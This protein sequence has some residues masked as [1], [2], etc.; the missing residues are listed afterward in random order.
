LCIINY[1]LLK[2]GAFKQKTMTK[3]EYYQKITGWMMDGSYV[4]GVALLEELRPKHEAL[5]FFKKVDESTPGQMHYDILKNRLQIELSDLLSHVEAL[6][7]KEGV[8]GLIKTS[9]ATGNEQ[10]QNEKTGL[11]IIKSNSINEADLPE[12]LK[13]VF[14]RAKELTPLMASLHSEL[15]NENLHADKAAE[16]TSELIRLDDERTACWEKLDAWAEGRE[17]IL[18]ED[19]PEDLPVDPLKRGVELA[20]RINRLK[21]NIA[22]TKK[23]IENTDR[24]N[25]RARNALKLKAYEQE[26][27]D[28]QSQL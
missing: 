27:S 4:E 5:P 1:A 12:E 22:R 8:L 25:I 9:V 2:K 15:S 14:A 24:E 3:A 18:L 23:T 19:D 10:G 17:E 6:A 16:L 20:S 28:L 13:A 7:E 26:L 21:E 11:K